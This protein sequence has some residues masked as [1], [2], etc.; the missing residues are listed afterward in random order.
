[1]LGSASSNLVVLLAS[2]LKPVDD[3]R[4]RGKFAESLLELPATNVHI[5]GRATSHLPAEAPNLPQQHPIFRGS[6]LSLNR[7]AAQWR[8]WRL[9]RHLAPAIVFVHA[10]ELLPL[11]LLWQWLGHRRHF[12]YDIRENYALNISTQGVYQGFTRR[13]LA[14][15]LRQVETLAAQQASA[16]ILAEASYVNELPFLV[17]LPPQRVLVLENK[18]QPQAGEI[19]AVHHSAPKAAEPLRLLF[20]GTISEINGVREAIA[21]TQELRRIR[22][23]GAQLTIIGFCQQPELLRYLEQTAANDDWLTL[24]GGAQPVPHAAIVVAIGQADFGLLPYQPH[25]STWHC[26]PTKLF[27]YLAHG[28]PVLIPNNPL[29][30]TLVQQ[31]GAGLTVAF[32]QPTVAAAAIAASRPT[33][34]YPQGFPTE[35]LWASEAKKLRHLL[36]SLR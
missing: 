16:V 25:P 28:L 26:R 17:R 27:E 33:V 11:T 8:Y 3:T 22:P 20:S 1:V 14:G 13:L 35:V 36:E 2:V 7:L 9:L 12:V 4:M 34:F 18:Y 29:W 6:R 21:L 32:D 10:P 31:H 23:G 19:V 30:V 5:A 24:V 15:L